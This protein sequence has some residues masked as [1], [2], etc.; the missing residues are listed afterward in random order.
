MEFRELNNVSRK[1]FIQLLMELRKTGQVSED[2]DDTTTI[3]K[4]SNELFTIEQCA[5]Q[6]ALFYL[7]GFD[8][9]ASAITYCLFELSRQPKLMKQVQCEIDEM[10]EKHN[11]N[12][13][14]ENINE[15][16]F[17]DACLRGISS[18]FF[19]CESKWIFN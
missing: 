18:T 4:D 11:N 3:E 19:C 14:Y 2:D 17:L 5:A 1:D 10:M 13:T 8:T 9:T 16:S 6:V 15:M 12:I 7:A